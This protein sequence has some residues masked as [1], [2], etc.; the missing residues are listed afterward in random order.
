MQKALKVELIV[1][2]TSP[3]FSDEDSSSDSITSADSRSSND[4][5]DSWSTSDES[6]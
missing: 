6:R 2:L 1:S 5:S 3:R 4:G